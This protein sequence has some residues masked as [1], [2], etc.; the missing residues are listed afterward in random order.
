VA[1]PGSEAEVKVTYLVVNGM[2][3]QEDRD[4]V[5]REYRPDTNGNTVALTD[6]T[7]ATDTWEYWPYGEVRTRTGTNPTP[8]QFVGTLGYYTDSANSRIYVRARTYR[9]GLGRW[10]T[11]DPLWPRRSA[12]G[13]ARMRPQTVA[14]PSGLDPIVINLPPGGG[15]DHL[16][17]DLCME[18]C[19][20][21]YLDDLDDCAKEYAKCMK[22]WWWV[23][24]Y[25]N[26]R[27]AVCLGDSNAEFLECLVCCTM[28]GPYD[29]V[30]CLDDDPI[31]II[32]PPGPGVVPS[33]CHHEAEE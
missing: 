26:A 12:Y 24:F 4:G 28:S 23:P 1:R 17:D 10:Q 2:I 7:T 27:L 25:C 6:A 29:W 15:L 14:D 30:D 22:K 21:E 3:L 31:F 13:Y 32:R 33:I 18:Y 5:V 8:F 19:H 11:V 9:Q 20:A 16:V